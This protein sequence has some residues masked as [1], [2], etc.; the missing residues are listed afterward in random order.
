MSSIK[1]AGLGDRKFLESQEQALPYNF[2]FINSKPLYRE[3]VHETGLSVPSTDLEVEAEGLDLT[4][5]MLEKDGSQIQ[6]SGKVDK[7]LEASGKLQAGAARNLSVQP[8]KKQTAVFHKRTTSPKTLPNIRQNAKLN[9]SGQRPTQAAKAEAAKTSNVKTQAKPEKSPLRKTPQQASP[10][11]KPKANKTSSNPRDASIGPSPPNVKGSIPPSAL[12]KNLRAV[13]PKVTEAK[14]LKKKK[15]DESVDGQSTP[16]NAQQIGTGK[17]ATNATKTRPKS[18]P[19]IRSI[20]GVDR[21]QVKSPKTSSRSQTR[22]KARGDRT[23]TEETNVPKLKKKKKA[24]DSSTRHDIYGL[25]TVE[26]VSKTEDCQDADAFLSSPAG[27]STASLY[28]RRESKLEVKLASSLS[29]SSELQ[30]VRNKKKQRNSKRPREKKP[31][32]TGNYDAGTHS[33]EQSSNDESVPSKLAKAVISSPKSADFKLRK[34]AKGKAERQLF[35]SQA[36]STADRSSRA[37]EAE[38]TPTKKSDALLYSSDANV[39]DFNMSQAQRNRKKKAGKI[40]DLN[41]SINDNRAGRSTN[42]TSAERLPPKLLH[43]GHAL[44]IGQSTYGPSETVSSSNQGSVTDHH[45][46][47]LQQVRD[48]RTQSR[49]MTDSGFDID[50]AYKLRSVHG[51]RQPIMNVVRRGDD[52][53]L[54]ALTP[55]FSGDYTFF[56]C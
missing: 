40:S 15:A 25:D 49:R 48:L 22:Q 46:K 29:I 23:D 14:A 2:Q 28:R 50:D 47:L 24:L 13:S 8:A 45:K 53:K 17:K 9:A 10:D 31:Q 33:S 36:E 7:G 1:V 4:E 16:K 43:R 19:K 44:K 39:S 42:A 18:P 51:T 27:N 52:T 34:R 54:P 11:R 35:G 3:F 20:D 38:I 32:R 26:Q 30:V 5:P 41:K 37:S 6:Q 21:S 55:K 56:M 12:G